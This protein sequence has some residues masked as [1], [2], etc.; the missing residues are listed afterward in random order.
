MVGQ[1]RLGASLSEVQWGQRMPVR[2]SGVRYDSAGERIGVY[3]KLRYVAEF[4]NL[5]YSHLCN[6]HA[7]TN[8]NSSVFPVN[9]SLSRCARPLMKT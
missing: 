4:I 9:Q 2:S 1:K 3:L 8:L 7:W 6:K 5:V